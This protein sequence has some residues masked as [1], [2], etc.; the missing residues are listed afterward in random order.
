MEA[1]QQ[2]VGSGRNPH[3]GHVT[4]LSGAD[5]VPSSTRRSLATLCWPAAQCSWRMVSIT[6]MTEEG[7]FR[8]VFEAHYGAVTRFLRTRGHDGTEADDLVAGTF[9]VAWRRMDQVPEGREALPWLIGVARNLSRNARRKSR[10]EASFVDELTSVTVPFT[11]L[12]IEDRAASA[13]VMGA[14]AQL[15]P[16]DRDLILLVAWDELTPQEAGQVVGLRP[17]TARSRLHRARRRLGEL[18]AESAGPAFDPPPPAS[19]TSTS[20]QEDRRGR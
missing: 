15:K 18:L 7:R 13:E 3:M 5:Q 16:V 2:M 11:E 12:P 20:P 19:S 8:V 9:E 4:V 10:R 17:V 14:L 1:A 6:H